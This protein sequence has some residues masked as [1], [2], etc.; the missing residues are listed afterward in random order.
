MSRFQRW[1]CATKIAKEQ[2]NHRLINC[3]KMTFPRRSVAILAE[4]MCVEDHNHGSELASPSTPN[5]VQFEIRNSRQKGCLS[6]ICTELNSKETK[7][8]GAPWWAPWCLI[9]TIA[10]W[11][12]AW[13]NAWMIGGT[14]SL[15]MTCI[16]WLTMKSHFSSSLWCVLSPDRD[17]Q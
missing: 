15:T 4:K 10:C 11:L 8:G 17:E 7:C 9:R 16:A 5:L 2:A 3:Q 12:S 1:Q 6:T 14:A 13:V